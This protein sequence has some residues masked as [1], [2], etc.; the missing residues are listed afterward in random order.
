MEKCGYHIGVYD[1]P[2]KYVKVGNKQ[3]A[4]YLSKSIPIKSI[5]FKEFIVEK[6]YRQEV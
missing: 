6:M 4:F 2:D 1:C 5:S 3:I